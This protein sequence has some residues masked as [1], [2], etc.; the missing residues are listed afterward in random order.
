MAV[1]SLS[2]LAQEMGLIRAPIPSMA[3]HQVPHAVSFE[4]EAGIMKAVVLLHAII[5][6]EIHMRLHHATIAA[7]IGKETTDDI[8]VAPVG[9]IEL[10]L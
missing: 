2:L 9:I 3:H 4:G 8:L 1:G 6:I 7:T 5:R 10:D